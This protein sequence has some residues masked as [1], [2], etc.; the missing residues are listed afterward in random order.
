M[1]VGGHPLPLLVGRDGEVT[2]VGRSGPLL[3]ALDDVVLHDVD[4]SLGDETLLLYTD[5]LTEARTADGR[6]GDARLVSLLAARRAARAPRSSS[7]RS[8]R[9]CSPRAAAERVTT[10]RCWP[11]RRSR[12]PR[13]ACG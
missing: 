6:F 5:G 8:R 9:R 1:A 10:S 12:P 2:A 13:I 3:G 4:F 7:S 11:S